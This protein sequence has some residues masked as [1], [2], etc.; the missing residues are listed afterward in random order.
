[1]P[2]Q[3]LVLLTAGE[4]YLK[5]GIFST[6]RMLGLLDHT[7]EQALNDGF[8]GI[9][10]CADMSWVLH[11]CSLHLNTNRRRRRRPRRACISFSCCCQ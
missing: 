11:A 5:D 3:S 7:V 4:T 1:M 2:G 9:R 8:A 10:A 6:E